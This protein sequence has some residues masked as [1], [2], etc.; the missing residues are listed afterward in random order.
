MRHAAFP[1]RWVAAAPFTRVFQD[2]K[3]S[4]CQ[5]QLTG[6]SQRHKAEATIHCTPRSVKGFKPNC[7]GPARDGHEI[8]AFAAETS[9][10]GS[11]GMVSVPVLKAI[12]PDPALAHVGHAHQGKVVRKALRTVSHQVLK[13]FMPNVWC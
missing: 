9:S 11:H 8:S 10:G 13:H 4:R 1:I 2:I 3:C 7:S 12:V 6:I 5:Q